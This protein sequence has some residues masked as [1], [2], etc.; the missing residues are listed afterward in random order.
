M[1]ITE[2]LTEIESYQDK[3]SLT[4][5]YLFN[6]VE[7]DP[8]EIKAY[9]A[10]T[11]PKSMY[12]KT[13]TQIK[14]LYLLSL[15]PAELLKQI[16]DVQKQAGISDDQAINTMAIEADQLADFKAGRLPTMNY[17]TALNA[18]KSQYSE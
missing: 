16:D 14:R 6:I 12:E 9:R 7:L 4:D 13:L 11:A 1:T 10:K 18:L 5:A 8:E 15:S 3:L 2:M 17:V